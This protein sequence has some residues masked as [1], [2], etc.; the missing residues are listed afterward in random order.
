MGDSPTDSKPCEE[1]AQ[2]GCASGWRGQGRTSWGC[3]Q[4]EGPESSPPGPQGPPPGTT[5]TAEDWQGLGFLSLPH[6][7]PFGE[8]DS[9]PDWV[10]GALVWAA[11]SA[12]P[13]LGDS[14]C[15]QVTP[16]SAWVFPL[17]R[18]SFATHLPTSCWRGGGVWCWAVGELASRGF[19]YT[20][21]LG[22]SGPQGPLWGL[23]LDCGGHGQRVLPMDA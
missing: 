20:Q 5:G 3:P 10:A 1:G 23:H 18:S 17:S 11:F 7:Q 22:G 8:A 4:H 19:P 2:A 9:D 16:I 12:T 21:V 15:S 13:Y 6:L 14:G